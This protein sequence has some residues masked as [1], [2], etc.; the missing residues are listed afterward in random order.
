[1]GMM[2][3]TAPVA[4][5]FVAAGLLLTACGGGD[6]KKDDAGS[7]GTAGT[8]AT[9]GTDSKTDDNKGDKAGPAGEKCTP[10]PAGSDTGGV[11]AYNVGS[12]PEKTLVPSNSNEMAG[13]S[14]MKPIFDVLVDFD[15]TGKVVF[16]GR[17]AAENITI[18]QNGKLFKVK[19]KE[20]RTF[21]DG[22]PVNADSFIKAWNFAANQKN[23]QQNAAFFDKIKGFKDVHPGKDKEPTAET[24]SG[25]VKVDDLN[26]TI[27]LEKP[28]IEFPKV[29]GYLA[30]APL[31]EA[32]YGNQEGFAKKPIGN[33]PFMSDSEFKKDEGIKLKTFAEYKGDKAKI[34][35]IHMKIYKE[36]K[37][38]YLEARAGNVDITGVPTDSLKTFRKEFKGKCLSQASSG[39][40]YVAFPTYDERFKDKRVRQAIS[41]GIDRDGII[42]AIFGDNM[43]PARSVISP[44]VAGHREKPCKY[45]DLNVEE[46]KKKLQEANFDTNKPIEL[47]FN[48]GANHDL[49]M[50]AI[51]QQLEKNLAI[52]STLKGDLQF[53]EYLPKLSKKEMTGP[54]RLGWGMDYPSA[55]NYLEPLYATGSQPPTG[56]NS[57]FYSN[58]EF[59][60]LVGEGNSAATP[61]EAI[62]KYQAAEDVLLEDLPVMPFAFGKTHRVHSDKIGGLE[63]DIFSDPIW[64]K[65][66]KKK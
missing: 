55:Q 37:T 26:F 22:T 20:G 19:L 50:G 43:T 10:A 5:T 17:A 36:P 11:V 52:K 62:K 15:K 18:E 34:D 14:I 49:W 23:A 45:C 63:L 1:M 24:M 16:T 4:A 25:L 30:F 47:W 44:L 42:K 29:I 57:S 46:A 8:T 32:F 12:N 65:M 39:F 59:D 27:E 13:I 54:F 31:P 60:K 51:K 66:T 61:E 38:A 6:T 64:H 7:K 21:H 53:N 35:G 9:Q 28:F 58:P 3:R 56:S 2:T 41:M 48:A 40:T 33:G